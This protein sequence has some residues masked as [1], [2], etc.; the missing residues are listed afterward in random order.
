MRLLSTS[1]GFLM[2]IAFSPD[3]L[4]E[5]PLKLQ[6]RIEPAESSADLAKLMR[7]NTVR[8]A[9]QR[10]RLWQEAA[11][12]E[13]DREAEA[14]QL[15]ADEASAREQKQVQSRHR[16]R[17][18]AGTP[19]EEAVL[20]GD[21]AVEPEATGDG[22]GS[23][24]R[25]RSQERL[26]SES[27]EAAGTAD[28]ARLRNMLR[29]ERLAGGESDALEQ[30]LQQRVREHQ[31]Q[32]ERAKTGAGSQHRKGAGGSGGQQKRSGR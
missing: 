29:E 2:V 22:T 14:K 18:A 11:Q 31:R 19:V 12:R 26:E 17:T 20:S 28:R 16:K 3:A 5:T 9:L 32:V 7:Q 21:V 10:H 25:E 15:S 4:A 8:V 27:G 1:I 23:Q 6:L 30:K 24:I 13:I